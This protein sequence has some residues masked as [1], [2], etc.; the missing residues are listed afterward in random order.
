M[1]IG[2]LSNLRAGGSGARVARVME[3]IRR[4][5]EIV[6]AEI[7]SSDDAPKATDV[8][9]DAGV[10]ILVINGGDG[11]L[12]RSMTEVL[13][14]ASPFATPPLIAP[15][16]TGRTSMS[17]LDI[18]SHR[19]PVLAIDHL[20]ERVRAGRVEEAVTDR[21]ALRMVLS[22]DG[23]DHY[24]T[25]FGV[26]VI[27]RG[28]LLTHRVFPRGRAQ[29]V[30]GS[31]LVTLGL[32]ARALSGG[33]AEILEADPMEIELDGDPVEARE[34]QLVI[35]TTLRRLFLHLR[36]FWG[37]G[38]GGLHATLI[39]AGGLRNVAAIARVVR[40]KDPARGRIDPRYVSR[41]VERVE[42]SLDCGA[43]LDGEMFE[44]SP[45]RRA[46]LQADRR[47]RFLATL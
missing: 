29:G 31:S 32:L 28:I 38:P 15:L 6:H 17:A 37:L 24:G 21:A 45:G 41:N 30:F 43:T 20:V 42:M 39:A 35:V 2:V 11:T 44:P 16:R 1:R 22:P 26:G 36:P 7:D 8:L 27:Y 19:D 25:F 47:V 23:V 33:A 13:C 9:A 3:R 14:D 10:E 4:Y 12:Q 40:G 18:G 5:P 46:S 34:F